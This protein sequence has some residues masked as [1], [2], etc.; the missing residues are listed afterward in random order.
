MEIRMLEEPGRRD[1]AIHWREG[2]DEVDLREVV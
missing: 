1:D 2:K